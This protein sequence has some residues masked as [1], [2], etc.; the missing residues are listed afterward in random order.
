MSLTSRGHYHKAKP[1]GEDEQVQGEEE[2]QEDE[3]GDDGCAKVTFDLL[4]MPLP[5]FV[6]EHHFEMALP[7][8]PFLEERREEEWGEEIKIS[9][10]FDQ[11]AGN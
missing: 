3:V 6:G 2:S 8:W 4:H 1:E 11:F 5:E 10:W 7:L 9:F